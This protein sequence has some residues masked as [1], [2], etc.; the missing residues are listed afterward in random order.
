M[1]RRFA[2]GLLDGSAAGEFDGF[3]SAQ[4]VVL[5]DEIEAHLHPRWKMQVMTSLRNA[6]PNMTF[7]VTTHDPLCLR[8]MRRGEVVVL[9]RTAGDSEDRPVRIEQ[10]TDLPDMT[11]MRVDQL[12]TS[13][14][15]QLFST[16][17]TAA[18][19]RMA[20]IGDLLAKRQAGEQLEG[21][22]EELLRAFDLEIADAL[23]VGSSEVQRIIQE[24]VADFLRQRRDASAR[25]LV[26]LRATTKRE[27]LTALQSV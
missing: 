19:L 10:M 16:T 2:R 8:G 5:I 25:A 15:F 27:I 12:L 20:R 4:G 23:P 9:Q 13:D 21:K 18:E 6:L 17:D 3:R 11:A 22:D 14:L 1:S 24:S 26:S 7:I